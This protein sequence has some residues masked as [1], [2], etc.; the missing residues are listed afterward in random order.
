MSLLP[1]RVMV[2]DIWDGFGLDVPGD[3]PISEL[4]ARA[5]AQ[6]RISRDPRQYMVKFRGAE[7]KENGETVA[8][9]GLVP[10]SELI[11]LRRRRWPAK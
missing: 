6:A 2:L 5:L 9:A 10:N 1:V 4:K 11:V 8:S 7:V 3:L